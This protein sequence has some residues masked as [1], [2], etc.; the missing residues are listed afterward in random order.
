[1]G[2]GLNGIARN[3]LCAVP[4]VVATNST[5]AGGVGGKPGTTAPA[6]CAGPHCA[7]TYSMVSRLPSGT[8]YVAKP[9]SSNATGDGASEG[10]FVI[11]TG[12][13]VFTTVTG[14]GPFL[15]SADAPASR[16]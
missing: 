11:W 6:V 12:R 1:M 7:A 13:G 15:S 4:P 16:N 9:P 3:Q 8:E 5:A 14:S 2:I 10:L